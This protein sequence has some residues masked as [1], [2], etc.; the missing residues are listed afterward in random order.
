MPARTWLLDVPSGRHVVTVALGAL[1]GRLRITVDG[2]EVF[3]R[4]LVLDV[5]TQRAL[6]VPF[7]AQGHA[8]VV[9]LRPRVMDYALELMVD[10]QPFERRTAV[11]PGVTVSEAASNAAAGLH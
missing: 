6:D 9:Q 3:R 4:S 5:T 10:G 2:E 7:S 8:F 1:S 11:G